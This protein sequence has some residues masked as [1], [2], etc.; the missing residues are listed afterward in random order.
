MEHNFERV[1][2]WSIFNIVIMLC[3]GFIQVYMIRSLFEDKSKIGRALRGKSG[4]VDNSEIK[5]SYT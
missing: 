2:F 5:R 1:N 3:V 4:G